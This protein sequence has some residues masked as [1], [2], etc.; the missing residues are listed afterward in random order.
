MKLELT[1]EQAQ[2]LIW[3]DLEG[4][5]VIEDEIVDNRRWS[6]DHRIVVKRLEDGKFL[7]TRIA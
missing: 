2:E 6:I 4:F 5:E 7:Q 3:G 1:K